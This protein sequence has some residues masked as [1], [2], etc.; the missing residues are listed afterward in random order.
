MKSVDL[1]RRAYFA[2]ADIARFREELDEHRHWLVMWFSSAILP[3]R[4]RKTRNHLADQGTGSHL[5]GPAR[6]NGSTPQHNSYRVKHAADQSIRHASPVAPAGP[7]MRAN[8]ATS[9]TWLATI[10]DGRVV[11]DVDTLPGDLDGGVTHICGEFD[12]LRRGGLVMLTKSTGFTLA[13]PSADASIILLEPIGTHLTTQTSSRLR[14][15]TI[16]GSSK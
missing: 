4:A 9:R 11:A 6:R 12:R 3:L 2:D 7:S 16:I 13:L 5:I 15:P 14:Q 8:P 1:R 10:S